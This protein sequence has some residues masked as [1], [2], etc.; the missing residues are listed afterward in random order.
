MTSWAVNYGLKSLISGGQMEIKSSL[1]K[2]SKT[3]RS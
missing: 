2:V 1:F 3:E